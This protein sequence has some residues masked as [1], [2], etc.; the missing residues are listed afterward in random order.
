MG[1]SLSA[2]LN[3][4]LAYAVKAGL[5]H[6]LHSEVAI[7]YGLIKA[8][9]E[10][11]GYEAPEITSGGRSVEQQRDLRRRWLAGEP[12][13]YRPAQSSWHIDGLALDVNTFAP[14]YDMFY[15]AWKMLPGGRA[16][17]DFRLSDPPHFDIGNWPAY[18]FNPIY[19]RKAWADNDPLNRER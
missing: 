9:M 17:K 18:K 15:S 2:L 10:N 8:F 4:A 5:A 7:R 6:K 14:G 16:G 1:S 12:G 19:P 11:A 13:I 3:K